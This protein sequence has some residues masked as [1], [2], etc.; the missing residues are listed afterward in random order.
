MVKT[1]KLMLVEIAKITFEDKDKPGE[2]LTRWK[3][4]FLDEAGEH[5]LGYSEKEKHRERVVEYQP[6]DFAKAWAYELK[7]NLW[8]GSVTWRVVV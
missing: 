1:Q 8:D 5:V 7:G 4:T 6:F 3:Y 2:M